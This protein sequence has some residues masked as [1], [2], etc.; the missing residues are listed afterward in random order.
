MDKFV[1]RANIDHYRKLIAKETDKETDP[2]KREAL[3]R[4]LAEEEAKLRSL[5]Q[6]PSDKGTSEA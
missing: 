1:A 5:T 6:K 3:A 4:L 2:A